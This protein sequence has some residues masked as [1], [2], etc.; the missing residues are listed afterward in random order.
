MYGEEIDSGTQCMTI[1]IPWL[2]CRLIFREFWFPFFSWENLLLLLKYWKYIDVVF[3]YNPG[4]ISLNTFGAAVSF[5]MKKR[6]KFA[7][8]KSAF[9]PSDSDHHTLSPTIDFS[10]DSSPYIPSLS[11]KN[12]YLI[13]TSQFDD[14][15]DCV[16][17]LGCPGQQLKLTLW[18]LLAFKDN[19]ISHSV[20]LSVGPSVCR[21][22]CC[23]LCQTG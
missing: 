3:L 19:D 13:M 16:G 21:S 20:G 1:W 12:A 9:K 18:Y 22:R 2:K 6:S 23:N 15:L 10:A 4:V 8:S 5:L 14:L 17:F 11:D 7:E